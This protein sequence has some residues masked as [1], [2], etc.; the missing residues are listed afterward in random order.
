MIALY[1]QKLLNIITIDSMEDRLV[2]SFHKY[3]ASGYTILRARGEGASGLQADISG[4]DANIMVK[5]I[6]PEERLSAILESLERKI[7][8]G[9]HLTV[10]ITDV[11]V[12]TPEKFAKP[13][14]ER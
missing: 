14:S 13:L 11:Q 12:M 10:F 1:P 7:L 8:K 9:Y 2:E 4:F 5:V 6:V 3:G